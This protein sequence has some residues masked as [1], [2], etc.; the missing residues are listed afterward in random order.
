MPL[1][2]GSFEALP[3][4][5]RT[6]SEEVACV[7]APPPKHNTRT[8]ARSLICIRVFFCNGRGRWEGFAGQGRDAHVAGSLRV[9]GD[10]MKPGSPLWTVR[11][12]AGARTTAHTRVSCYARG[13]KIR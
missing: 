3:T 10:A 4:A 9:D 2:P 8:R 13:T 5:Q 12:W 1:P 7:T 11:S 6:N